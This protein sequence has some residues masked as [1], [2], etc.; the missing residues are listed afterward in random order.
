MRVVAELVF[1]STGVEALQ[2]LKN[3]ERLISLGDK[4]LSRSQDFITSNSYQFPSFRS[5][6]SSM[7]RNLART[8]RNFV[9]SFHCWLLSVFR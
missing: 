3:G 2:F 7:H 6:G 4:F 9:D 8:Y 1:H 5:G